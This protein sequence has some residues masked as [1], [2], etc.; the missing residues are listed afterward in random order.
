MVGDTQVSAA[1]SARPGRA[2]VISGRKGLLL[3]VGRRGQLAGVCPHLH[4]RREGWAEGGG[5]AVVPEGSV[6]TGTGASSRALVRVL[7]WVP[8][9]HLPAPG[10]LSL[11]NVGNEMPQSRSPRDRFPLAY[12]HQPAA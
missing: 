8:S 4:F 7:D 1:E 11:G 10:P 6:Q 2:G 9:K 3:D 5:H 12:C